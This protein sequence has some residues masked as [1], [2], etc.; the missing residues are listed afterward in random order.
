MEILAIVPAR[1]LTR[2]SHRYYGNRRLHDALRENPF[3]NEMLSNA[4]GQRDIAGYMRSG[5]YQLRNPAGTEW[6]HPTQNPGVVWLIRQCDHRNPDY[7]LFLHPLPN[8]AGG[9]SQNF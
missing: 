1:G 3:Y 8:G 5:S 4:L 6:H 7:Q 9:F 2:Q